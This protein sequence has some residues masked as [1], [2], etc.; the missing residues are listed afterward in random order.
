MTLRAR[1]LGLVLMA[2]LGSVGCGGGKSLRGPDAAVDDGHLD[3]APSDDSSDTGNGTLDARA[4]LKDG[5][6][7]ATDVPVESV[8]SCIGLTS[9]QCNLTAGCQVATCANCQGTTDFHS[10]YRP[11]VDA[12]PTC[13]EPPCLAWRRCQM[14]NEYACSVSTE[15]RPAYCPDC[16]GGRTYRGCQIRSS[17]VICDIFCPS[18]DGAAD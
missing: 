2:L 3:V 18:V 5:D 17:D 13:I 10:C 8:V 4:D 16:K 6:A 15:C 12:T 9:H 11:G 14:L 1:S 7:P